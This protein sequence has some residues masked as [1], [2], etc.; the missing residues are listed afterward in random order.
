MDPLAPFFEQFTLTARMF[1]SGAFCGISPNLDE[2]AGYLHVLKKGRLTITHPNARPIVIE[3]PS[4]IFLPRPHQHRLHASEEEGTELVCAT[5]EFGTGMLNPLTASFPEPFII[6]LNA[7]PELAPTLHFLFVESSSDLP[8]R[9][10]ALDRLFEYILVLLIRT[11]INAHLVDGGVLLGLSDD[12][13][14]KAIEAMH[15]HPEVSWSLEELAQCAGMSRAR[16]AVHFRKVVGTT[17]FDYLTNWR[18]GIAQTKLRKGNSLK[19][20]AAAVG[21]TH[22]TALTRIFTQRLGV[23]PTDWLAGSKPEPVIE[24]R[25]HLNPR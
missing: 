13:L 3:T 21:Y 15:K 18:L 9:Q 5:V 7:L 23:S 1:Y 22:A 25:A 17:P 14:S 4:I 11:A 10:T 6:P 8:G 12:R 2:Q 24:S 20:I 19:L 16:F